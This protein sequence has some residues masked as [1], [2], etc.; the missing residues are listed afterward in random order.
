MRHKGVRFHTNLC[1][2]PRGRGRAPRG[3]LSSGASADLPACRRNYG[4]SVGWSRV[5]RSSCGEQRRVPSG[6]R[7]SSPSSSSRRRAVS[8]GSRPGRAES[9]TGPR[10]RRR[11]TK[12][13]RD[14]AA[15]HTRRFSP[16]SPSALVWARPRSPG[17]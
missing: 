3:P 11:R 1:A 8:T 9:T 16:S 7:P 15:S 5:I 10:M 6:P 4:M 2:E 17:R 12:T 14:Q 13:R